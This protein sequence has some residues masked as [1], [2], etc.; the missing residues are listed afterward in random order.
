MEHLNNYIKNKVKINSPSFSSTD[1]EIFSEPQ[2]ENFI[3]NIIKKCF[4]TTPAMTKSDVTD[5]IA[6]EYCGKNNATMDI[7]RFDKIKGISIPMYS[8]TLEG[9]LNKYFNS[10]FGKTNLYLYPKTI[11]ISKVKSWLGDSFIGTM[12]NPNI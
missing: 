8:K 3:K 4:H 2:L 7:E 6:R 11:K 5:R 1:S 9:V 12:E 10:I